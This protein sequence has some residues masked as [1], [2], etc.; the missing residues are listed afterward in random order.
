MV[1]LGMMV[2]L[3]LSTALQQVPEADEVLTSIFDYY[4]SGESSDHCGNRGDHAIAI[5]EQGIS[6]IPP[7]HRD[8]PAIVHGLG[9]LYARQFQRSGNLQALELAVQCHEKSVILCPGAHGDRPEFLRNLATSY[10]CRFEQLKSLADIDKAI[11][12]INEAISLVPIHHPEMSIFQCV[13]GSALTCR[14]QHLGDANDI[15]NAIKHLDE[16]ASLVSHDRENLPMLL[17]WRGAAYCYRFERWVNPIDLDKATNCFI[18]AFQNTAEEDPRLPD[19]LNNVAAA[20]FDR[21]H[22]LGYQDDIDAAIDTL[23]RAAKLLPDGDRHA[24]MYFENLGKL[25]GYRFVNKSPRDRNI[26]DARDALLCSMH[27][28]AIVPADHAGRCRT[29]WSLGNT[30]V[31]QFENFGDIQSLDQAIK[32]FQESAQLATGPLSARFRAAWAWAKALRV[33][34]TVSLVAYRYALGLVPGYVW[35]GK[36]VKQRYQQIKYISHL[37]I[38]AVSLAIEW[39]EYETALEFLEMGRSIVW[40]QTLQLRTP[41]DELRETDSL[42]ACRIEEVARDLENAGA[43]EGTC[44]S[45]LAQSWFSVEESVQTQHRLAEEWDR[46]V[47]QACMIPGF[48]NFLAPKT[49]G[50]LVKATG[51]GAVVVVDVFWGNHCDALALLPDGKPITRINLP[52]F[53]D[54]KASELLLRLNVCLKS[55]GVRR[56][57]ERH[58]IYQVE[59]ASESMETILA[60]LWLDLV[61]P[62]LA[63]LKYLD[64]QD[65]EILPRVTWCATGALAFLPIHAAG[66][67]NDGSLDQVY[68]YVVSSYTPSLQALI[69]QATKTPS[70]YLG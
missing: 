29:I 1:A 18:E 3:N 42:L 5:L 52:S 57:G 58:P 63:A 65:S 60:T 25:H 67:Y 16:A 10:V 32:Y 11:S 69:P 20:Y 19:R 2:L 34:S 27:A 41:V 51:L 64:V 35:I 30:F 56:R 26:C 49:M 44:K 9:T 39:E 50:D 8:T 6:L 68:N 4:T 24:F 14:F 17:Y 38:E 62:V 37:A 54:R 61:K 7:G 31:G 53:S 33:D 22:L 36:I 15:D 46:L 45:M 55:V 47:S 48:H 13:L 23:T 43:A 40:H 21:F 66:C 12:R 70:P 28:V 59:N